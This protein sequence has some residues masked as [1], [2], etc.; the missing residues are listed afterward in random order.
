MCGVQFSELDFFKYCIDHTLNHFG[1][2]ETH[3]TFFLRSLFFWSQLLS[4]LY[5]VAI[6]MLT[7]STGIIE[8]LFFFTN[9][10]VN[11][12]NS[13]SGQWIG[14]R[15]CRCCC[16]SFSLLLFTFV[17]LIKKMLRICF[18]FAPNNTH[19]LHSSATECQRIEG[20]FKCFQINDILGW[21][22]MLNAKHM[23]QQQTNTSIELRR[24]HSHT[25]TH[26]CSAHTHFYS[27]YYDAQ[28]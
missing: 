1:T 5:C 18:F 19:T 6:C 14:R 25:Q 7:Q 10:W 4:S 13:K 22:R 3:S 23:K 11:S 2:T 17:L 12:V 27:H 9:N 24:E 8:I 20:V 26:I 16:C 28:R 21:W 15:R